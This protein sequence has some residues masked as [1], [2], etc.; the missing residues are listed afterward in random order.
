MRGLLPA[1]RD[2]AAAQH[3]ATQRWRAITSGGANYAEVSS[4]GR[5]SSAPPLGKTVPILDGLAS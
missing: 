5:G 1:L 3:V 2:D 4:R